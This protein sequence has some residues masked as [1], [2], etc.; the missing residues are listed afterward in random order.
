MNESRWTSSGRCG[1]ANQDAPRLR[2]VETAPE[3]SR[4]PVDSPAARLTDA[5]VPRAPT[6]GLAVDERAALRRARIAAELRRLRPII[7]V[8][9]GTRAL[10]L[11]VAAADAILRHH[12]FATEISQWDGR[13]YRDLT[14]HGYPTQ[15]LHTRTTLGFFPAYSILMWLLSHALAITPDVAGTIIA[16]IGGLIA[17]LLVE[18]L[19]S[20]WWGAESG[21]RAAILFCLFPGSIVFSMIYSEGV[22]ISLAAGC[23]LALERRRW[24]LAGCLAGAATATG[25]S[26]LA[27]IAVCAVAALVE[28]RRHGWQDRGA[29]ASLLAP[30]LSLVGV[31]AFAAFLWA[32]TGTPF[33]TLTAQRYGWGERTDPLALFYQ[34]KSLVSEISFTHFNHPTINLN[35]VIGLLGAVVL[36]IGLV[37]LLRKPRLVSLG[38]IVW[39]LGIAVL[40]TTSEYVPPNP[41]LLIT[42]FPAVVVFAYRLR[43]RRFVALALANGALLALLSALTYVGTTLR[44]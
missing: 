20:G 2:L 42:A 32:W 25:P 31:T 38:G 5:L 33:A 24:L 12:R 44:P 9:L 34:A 27:L 6:A 30:L 16:M 7:A 35:L 1:G 4:P 22:L 18:R 8:Y 19:A 14:E 21:R 26:A 3:R 10:L 23:I 36:V 41:R 15:D 39:T 43:G 13:W 11:V 17:T 28:L 29:R 40:A 37:L